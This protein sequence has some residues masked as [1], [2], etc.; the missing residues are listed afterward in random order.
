[1]LGIQSIHLV[2]MVLHKLLRMALDLCTGACG[3][4][5]FDILPISPAVMDDAVLEEGF[6]RGG[7]W[8]LP[9]GRAGCAR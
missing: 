6:F 5:L 3:D 8:T 9:E 2:G 4:V 7:P 1:M